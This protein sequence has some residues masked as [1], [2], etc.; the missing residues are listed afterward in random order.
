VLVWENVFG[1]DASWPER[2]KALLR[3]LLPILRAFW[4]HFA[5]ADWEPFVPAGQPPVGGTR[6]VGSAGHD[7][8]GPSRPG[9]VEQRWGFGV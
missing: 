9:R 6:F 5:A 7:E 4:E 2:D 1:N 3:A 8:A